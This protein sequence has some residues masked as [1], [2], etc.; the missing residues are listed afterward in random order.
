[1]KFLR[2]DDRFWRHFRSHLA[3]L[4]ILWVAIASFCLSRN[5]PAWT[6]S[7]CWAGA[8]L[9]ANAIFYA[10]MSMQKV[11]IG[12]FTI[13]NQSFLFFV[14]KLFVNTLTL[15]LLIGLNVVNGLVFVISFFAAYLV[16][17]G[18][19]VGLMHRDTR[20]AVTSTSDAEGI[21]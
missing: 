18:L 12:T 8:L 14:C 2:E 15:F 11:V 19:V 13:L 20:S 17:L 6:K 7:V 10:A 21:Q 4:A 9:S 1:M 16:Q 5:D 3:F